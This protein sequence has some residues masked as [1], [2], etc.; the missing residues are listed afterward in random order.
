VLV[1]VVRSLQ[2]VV[3]HNEAKLQQLLSERDRLLQQMAGAVSR[4]DL[5]KRTRA[6]NQQLAAVEAQEDPDYALMGRL[7]LEQQILEQESAQLP[8]SEADFLKLGDWH[9]AL[10]QGMHDMCR[11]LA[12]A[13]QHSKL[14]ELAAQLAELKAMDLSS[15]SLG[16]GK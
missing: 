11:D 15:L 9:A 6:I 3:P 16:S 8:L 12:R 14:K 1:F 2:V 13:R 5:V 10:V 4:R 7:M